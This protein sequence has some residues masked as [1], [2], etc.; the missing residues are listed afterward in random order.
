MGL[1]ANFPTRHKQTHLRKPKLHQTLPMQN[2]NFLRPRSHGKAHVRMKRWKKALLQVYTFMYTIYVCAHNIPR[3]F[4]AAC[5]WQWRWFCSESQSVDGVY[6]TVEVPFYWFPLSL[7]QSCKQWQ[8]QCTGGR[9]SGL[10]PLPLILHPISIRRLSD[11]GLCA[12]I[13]CG[14]ASRAFARFYVESFSLQGIKITFEVK[15]SSEILKTI[16]I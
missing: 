4:S 8:W 10:H 3:S 16:S 14:L 15:D 1:H 2:Q 13:W 12:S 5:V 6:R 9:Q 11:Y 7:D